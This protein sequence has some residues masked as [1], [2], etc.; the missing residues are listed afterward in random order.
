MGRVG[1]LV[2]YQGSLAQ[3]GCGGTGPAT[4]ISKV[5]SSLQLRTCLNQLAP[6]GTDCT[7]D[8]WLTHLHGGDPGETGFYHSERMC[9][10]NHR[11]DTIHTSKPSKDNERKNDRNTVYAHAGR[12]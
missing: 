12:Q 10:G 2:S 1:P 9:T 7:T 4:A 8:K 11:Y 6:K 5:L 3:R